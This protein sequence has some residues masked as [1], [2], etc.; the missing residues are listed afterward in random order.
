[1]PTARS[2]V[3]QELPEQL[4]WEEMQH[5]LPEMEPLLNSHRPRLVFDFSNVRQVDAAGIEMLLCCM[6]E[7]MKRGGDLKL[8]ALPPGPKKV[9][10]VTGVDRLFEIFD[11]SSDAVESFRLVPALPQDMPRWHPGAAPAES[12]AAMWQSSAASES[13]NL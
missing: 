7:V 4:T 3:V 1:M 6:E 11:N 10:E 5:F 2:V 13:H 12:D 9:L 8:A